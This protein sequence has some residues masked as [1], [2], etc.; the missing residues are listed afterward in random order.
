MAAGLACACLLAC[1]AGCGGPPAAADIL[2]RPARADIRD[3]HFS[4]SGA[5][6]AG[7]GDVV[8]RPRPALHAAETG[9]STGREVIAVDGVEYERT[10]GGAW[11]KR[12]SGA[13]VAAFTAWSSAADARYLGEETVAG[14]PCWH[15]AASFEGDALEVWVRRSDGYPVREV[16]GRLAVTYSRF[17]SGVRIEPPPPEATRPE[18]KNLHARLGETAHLTGVDVTVVDADLTRQPV[19]RSARA[20]AGGRFVT[21]EIAYQLAGAQRLAYGPFQWRL[22]DAG[23]FNYPPAPWEQEPRLGQGELTSAEDRTRGFLTFEVPTA[24]TGLALGATIGSDTLA[25]ALG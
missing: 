16:V 13:R 6:L 18:P 21:V 3:M 20:R 7:E 17:N 14:S 11:S 22:V 8:L 23:G 5:G 24:A 19:G 12:A 10:G 25:V 9:S 2:A 15:V 1:A 4:F